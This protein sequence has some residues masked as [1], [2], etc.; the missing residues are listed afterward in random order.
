MKLRVAVLVVLAAV[1]LA[2]VAIP[3]FPYHAYK[4]VPDLLP[5][6]PTCPDGDVMKLANDEYNILTTATRDIFIH[7]SKA[8]GEA[9]FIYFAEGDGK[10]GEIHIKKAMTLEDAQKMYPEGPCAY[11]KEITI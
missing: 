4:D 3:P 1:L 8:S 11:F 5:L 6:G 10:D 2:A 9:D 7:I